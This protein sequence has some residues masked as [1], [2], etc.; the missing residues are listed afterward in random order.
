MLCS[1]LLLSRFSGLSVRLESMIWMDNGP[2]KWNR[3]QKRTFSEP[4]NST[5]VGMNI[6]KPMEVGATAC[7][8]SNN[9]FVIDQEKKIKKTQT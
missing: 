8:M 4:G 9:N 2:T 3:D 6:L 5:T 1:L 7:Q